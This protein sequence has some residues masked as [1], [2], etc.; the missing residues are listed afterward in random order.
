MLQ[1][2]KD[3]KNTAEATLKEIETGTHEK[4]A[5]LEHAKATIRQTIKVHDEAIQNLA[6]AISVSKTDENDI[7]LA[8]EDAVATH[9]D[10]IASLN[11]D[12]GELAKHQKSAE[13]YKKTEQGKLDGLEAEHITDI[14]E[15]KDAVTDTIEDLK[16][17]EADQKNDFENEKLERQKIRQMQKD[18]HDQDTLD[19]Q[20]QI[21]DLQSNKAEAE[22]FLQEN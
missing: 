14:A 5:A 18:K 1:Q 9:N 8:E 6:A 3:Q 19:L 10:L 21:E 12:K 16:Q 2:L 17:A 7:K 15:L 13:G 22:Q 4:H 11:K 20:G